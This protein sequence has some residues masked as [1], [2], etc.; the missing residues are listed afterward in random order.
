MADELG[1]SSIEVD[2]PEVDPAA[3]HEARCSEER[4]ERV[5]DYFCNMPGFMEMVRRRREG[6]E[7]GDLIPWEGMKRKYQTED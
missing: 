2:G 1:M 6:A 4:A 3:V 7:A 5:R